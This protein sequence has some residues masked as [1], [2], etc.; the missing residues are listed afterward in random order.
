[1]YIVEY[2]LQW[3]FHGGKEAGLSQVQPQIQ[4]WI[5]RKWQKGPYEK[6]KTP[7]SSLAPTTTSGAWDLYSHS[8]HT[9]ISNCDQIQPFKLD[10]PNT[11]LLSNPSCSPWCSP[12]APQ[13]ISTELTQKVNKNKTHS[14]FIFNILLLHTNPSTS[15]RF[16]RIPIMLL[17]TS[18]T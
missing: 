8:H 16:P 11:P 3:L 18:T 15:N 6:T 5:R 10:P 9:S 13:T 17:F 7:F 4:S 12:G 2:M 1:M 14:S